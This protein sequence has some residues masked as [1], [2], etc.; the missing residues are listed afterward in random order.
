MAR[1]KHVGVRLTAAE[2]VRVALA[3]D[4][5]DMRPAAWVRHQAIRAADPAAAA[6]ARFHAPAPASPEAKLTR[7]A[8]T[9]FTDQQFSALA[10]HALACGL[11]LAA[12]IRQ[13]VLG[14]TPVARR[15]VAHA[16]VVALNRLGNN[17]N[18]L[19]HLA[20]TGVLLPPDLHRAVAAALGQVLAL[21]DALLDADRT[22]A[23]EPPEPPE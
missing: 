8:G 9:R 14:V 16:A 12:F 1:I 19:V 20:H 6:P 5:L 23:D 2:F 10:A 7:T 13:A 15:P 18:Q 11:P 21:R 17:L 4:A 22:G 3:A